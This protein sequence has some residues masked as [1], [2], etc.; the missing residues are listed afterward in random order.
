MKKG[1]TPELIRLNLIVEGRGVVWLKNIE[2]LKTPLA[3]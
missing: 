2:L 1:Q 3:S